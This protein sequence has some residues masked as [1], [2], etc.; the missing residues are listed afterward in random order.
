MEKVYDPKRIED[1]LYQFWLKN[2]YFRSE[3]DFAHPRFSI[4]IPPP[5]VTGSLHVGHAL[6]LTLQD[7]LTRWQRMLGKNA[8][9]VPGTDHAGIGTQIVVERELAKEGKNR[10]QIGREEFVKRAWEWKE[11]SHQRIIQ[12][13]RKLG[14]SCD[15]SRERFTLDEG[16]SKAVR[17]AFVRL[18]KEGLIYKD[19]YIVNWCPRCRTAISDLEVRYDTKEGSLYHIRY[20]VKNSEQFV[21][22]A[23]TRPETMLGDTAIAVHPEDERYKDFVGKTAILPLLNR[24]IPVIADSFVDRQFGTGAVKITPAHDPNDFLAA[25]RNNLP[26]IHVINGEGKMTEAAGPYAGLDRFEARKKVIEDLESQGFLIKKE[27]HQFALA[28]CD[29]CNTIVEPLLSLQWFARMS[30][31]AEPAI[32]AVEE[33]R[34]RF[35]PETW[36]KTFFEWMRNIRDWCISRQ[37]WWGHQI[38]AWYCDSCGETIVEVETPKSCPNC[39]SEK[40]RQETDVLDTW[41]SSGLWPM[42]VFGWPEITDDLKYYYPTNVLVTAFDII[43]F[44]VARMMMFGLKFMNDVPFREVY[45]HGLVR[46]EHG[47]KMSKSRGNT[48]DPMDLIEENGADALRFT[49]SVLAVP[50]P[51]IP[52]APKRVQGY[53]AFL[54]KLWNSVRF[55]LM[56]ISENEVLDPLQKEHWDIGDRWIYSRFNR[57]AGEI[58]NALAEYRFD[59]AANAAYQFLWYELCDWY[60]EWIK[61]HLADDY[62]QSSA[63]KALL[64]QRIGDV[65][66]LLHPF[67][68]FVTE[69][70]WQQLPAATRRDAALIRAKYP[71]LEPSAIDEEAEKQFGFLMEF[72]G[73]IRQVRSEMNIEP[74][75]KVKVY[76]RGHADSALLQE[77][78]T[79]IFQL[80][81]LEKMEFVA[82]MP[83]GMHLA[84]GILKDCEIGI[85]LTG[86]L[87]INAEIERL[88][89]ELKKIEVDLQQAQKKLDN[90]NFVKNAP[91]EVVEE[92]KTK[93]ADL[94]ARKE[95]TENTLQALSQ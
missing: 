49:L 3:V 17:T 55:A 7:I 63:R 68:P 74:S 53:R 48:I 14:L 90:E 95:R 15:W 36:A 62:P 20:P 93:F 26:A 87:D 25:K 91:A 21:E 4:V 84:R 82:D 45:I 2:D 52:L 33:G 67:V 94:T 11:Y 72:I 80:A 92:Q 12:Q 39:K 44:W 89:K 78:E 69:Y 9:W 31:L 61:P 47:Q 70:L 54:N 35:Y 73:K 88:K 81:R 46:D 40:L 22:V 29:R 8:L 18:Y 60:I 77:H 34:T 19:Q 50:A 5:N 32:K 16:L 13:I 59:L 1:E 23:T 37:L 75:K 71:E 79:E 58:N 57:T 64:L 41:F 30:V 24:E 43:F 27:K 51:D 28:H 83:S 10:Q 76:V 42:S 38:P 85:D 56:K 65:L 66:R 6:D 86:V